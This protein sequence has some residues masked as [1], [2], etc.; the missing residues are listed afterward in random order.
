MAVLSASKQRPV[1]LDHG[2]MKTRMLPLAGY[3]NFGGGSTAHT[4]YK[5]SIVICDVSDTD[6]YYRACPLSSSTN[7]AAGDVFG[8]IAIEEQAVTSDDT[9]DGAVEVAVAINGVWA[10]AVGSIAATDIG[11]A[12]YASDDD[13]ITTTS[14]NNI[15]IGVIVGVDASYVYVDIAPQV[16]RT[17]TVY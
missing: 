3:T 4:V 15:V 12:A 2:E 10:F 5:G 1:R 9:A 11:A 17:N 14:T 7:L 16:G 6:G 13:T 8:G